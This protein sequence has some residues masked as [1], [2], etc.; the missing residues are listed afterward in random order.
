MSE[1]RTFKCDK[2]NEVNGK[3]YSVIV[4]KEELFYLL[5]YEDS[6]SFENS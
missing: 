1:L 4:D 2:V 5:I 3:K 6:V